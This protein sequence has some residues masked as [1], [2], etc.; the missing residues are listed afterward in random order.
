MKNNNYDLKLFNAFRVVPI[1]FEHTFEAFNFEESLCEALA[2]NEHLMKTYGVTATPKDLILIAKHNASAD[3]FDLFK[4]TI[5]ANTNTYAQANAMYDPQTAR[6]I[7]EWQFRFHQM[8]HYFSTYGLEGL[9]GVNVAHG[10]L[11]AE[12]EQPEDKKTIKVADIALC[13]VTPF[14]VINEA[15]KYE[16]VYNKVT[17][18]RNRA[19]DLERELL[20]VAVKNMS[21]LEVENTSV[22]FK[23]NL[24]III[25][26]ILEV[27]GT[28]DS[29]EILAKFL[30]NPNDLLKY[31]KYYLDK[32]HWKL[33][34]S[35][36]KLFSK[37]LESYSV[38]SLKDNLMPSRKRREEILPIL[39]YISFTRYATNSEALRVVEDLRGKNLQ[40]FNSRVMAALNNHDYEE[41]LAVVSQRPGQL[42]RQV[43]MF[44]KAGVPARDI[45]DALVETAD[46]LSIQTLVEN[47][48]AFN[49]KA[50]AEKRDNKVTRNTLISIMETTL[51]AALSLK[52][53]PLR[54]KKVY[55][56]EGN[57][58]FKD[59]SLHFNSKSAAS[60]YIS[61]GIAFKLPEFNTD[62]IR[63][64]TYWKNTN[65]G[66]RVDIDLH[67]FFETKSGEALH[68]GWNGNHR[69]AGVTMSGD[70]THSD[71][72]GCEY[73]DIE[74]NK[75]DVKRVLLVVH[76][77]THQ[78]FKDISKCF[79]G[80]T[81]VS[82]AGLKANKSLYNQK[83]CIFA[84][85]LT[86]SE[87]NNM[88]YGYVDLEKKIVKFIGKDKDVHSQ[89][90]LD[91]LHGF[92]AEY[93]IEE[94]LSS[95]FFAQD[96]IIVDDEADADYVLRLDKPEKVNE[97][98]LIDENWFADK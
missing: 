83:N 78:K 41:A 81:A 29:K 24:N 31:V 70:I 82:E 17:S 57:F 80:L 94:Y 97:I 7:P 37:L 20:A 58:A 38:N 35:E 74:L 54:G 98:S 61:S 53:T 90:N 52:D 86:T 55:I 8:V 27:Y 47:L 56:K 3:I 13:D 91:V 75:S 66:Y 92:D 93:T 22:A 48:N 36:K 4:Y 23:E 87:L 43:R 40:S 76:N 95:L 6:T 16:Y 12:A 25:D 10:W 14:N 60:D 72:Y 85:D 71:P 45:T 11:P 67:S 77:F 15:D 39:N 46:K 63:L 28:A 19:T 26:T 59:S 51:I 5:F 49:S 84:H 88:L 34:S 96:V 65:D 50:Y 42:L 79:V 30:K 2:V 33:N 32:K 73:I 68:V 44:L 64:F 18:A 21:L 9:F 89:Y 62:T 1:K 69:I